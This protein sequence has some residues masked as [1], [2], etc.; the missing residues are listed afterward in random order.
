MGFRSSVRLCGAAFLL[1][2]IAGCG[3]SQHGD[4]AASAVPA[5]SVSA[6]IVIGQPDFEHGEPPFNG[7][8]IPI[9]RLIN[10]EGS[11]GVAGDGR[12]F[13]GDSRHLK[14]FASY[15]TAN[16]SAAQF[17]VPGAARH[18]SIRAGVLIA[19]QDN[20]V[21]ISSTLPTDAN[22]VPDNQIAGPAGCSANAFST[23]GAAFIT[24]QG[25]LIVADT[26]NNRVL[27]WTQVPANGE[28]ADFVV[29]QRDMVSCVADAINDEGTG[30]G[31]ST[32][33]AQTL[34]SPTSVWSDDTRLVVVD[35][36]NSRVLVWSTFPDGNFRAATHVIGQANFSDG[37]AN[38]GQAN[39]SNVS[40]SSPVSV[41][42]REGG[43]LAVADTGNNR[44]LVWNTFPSSDGQAA[45]QVIGQNGFTGKDANAGGAK[46]AANTLRAPTG[47]RFDR[48]NLVVTDTGNHR[49]LVFPSPN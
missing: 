49:V 22:A 42:V 14:M 35:S 6:R 28:D 44:V 36:G 3:G 34:D 2:A 37:A 45:T 21:E 23:P 5:A 27:I 13:V 38:L 9:D 10:P 48:S 33:S 47:V 8:V 19:S 30:D 16:G 17:A 26:L 12:L 31:A 7:P 11:V 1:A 4:H 39:A 40:L 25:R 18:L 24:P 29:G 32:S 46:P 43:Q 41:D 20:R 15:D